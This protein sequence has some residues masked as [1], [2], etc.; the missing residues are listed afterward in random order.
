[1]QNLEFKIINL[2]VFLSE[3]FWIKCQSKCFKTNHRNLWI[4]VK[5]Q[6][7]IQHWEFNIENL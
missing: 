1:M 6:F 3:I 2:M 5:I 4:N 7:K